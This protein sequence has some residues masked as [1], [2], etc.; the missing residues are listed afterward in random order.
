MKLSSCFTRNMIDMHRE[1]RIHEYFYG[2]SSNPLAPVSQTV[3]A[4]QLMVYR[5]GELC[6]SVRIHKLKP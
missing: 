6:V 5:I 3:R 2:T 1:R 4:D